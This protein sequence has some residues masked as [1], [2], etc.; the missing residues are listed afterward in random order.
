MDIQLPEA[1]CK[2]GDYCI[3]AYQAK[4]KGLISAEELAYCMYDISLDF[5]G[6][7]VYKSLPVMPVILKHKID[8]E[9]SKSVAKKPEVIRYQKFFTKINSENLSNVKWLEQMLDGWQDMED[10]GNF[11]KVWGTYKNYPNSMKS[12]KWEVRQDDS[13]VLKKVLD[14]LGGGVVE[15]NR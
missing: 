3:G 11:L 5:L 2:L 10:K 9:L 12:G 6:S 15:S 13:V 8:E 1:S 4:M 14:V 7:Y